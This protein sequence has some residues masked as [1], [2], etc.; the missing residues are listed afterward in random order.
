MVR[1]TLA[2]LDPGSS[3]A[4]LQML[5][6]GLAGAAVMAKLFWRRILSFLRIKRD[7]PEAERPSAPK[8]SSR[9]AG[10]RDG[11]H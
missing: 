1:S 5:A 10:G 6:G 9:S 8:S 11:V 3:S 2:Y 4:I 7:E